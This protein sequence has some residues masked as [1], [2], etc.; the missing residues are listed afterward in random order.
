MATM[1]GMALAVPTSE[2]EKP[3]L[4]KRKLRYSQVTEKAKPHRKADARNRR[5]SP[6]NVR[7][8]DRVCT[9]ANCRGSRVILDPRN[10]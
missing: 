4:S 7:C 9:N 5:E 8:L 3:R 6:V 10:P 1:L 2:S